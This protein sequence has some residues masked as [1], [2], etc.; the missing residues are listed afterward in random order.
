MFINIASTQ[1]QRTARSAHIFE[2]ATTV[3][4]LNFTAPAI[5]QSAKEVDELLSAAGTPVQSG[6]VMSGQCRLRVVINMYDV[7]ALS[8]AACTTPIRADWP[9]TKHCDYHTVIH[10]VKYPI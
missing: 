2:N 9:A 1:I 8:T 10:V 7:S 6:V 3:T 4:I 5:F